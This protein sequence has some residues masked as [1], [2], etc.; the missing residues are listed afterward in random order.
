[1]LRYLGK[2]A[3]SGLLARRGLPRP[4]E[5]C[6]SRLGGVYTVLVIEA[7]YAMSLILYCAKAL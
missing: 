5:F 1:M 3:D 4:D 6:I 2:E 7:L